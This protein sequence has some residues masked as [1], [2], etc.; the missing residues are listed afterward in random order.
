MNADSIEDICAALVSLRQNPSTKKR[1]PREI[2]DAIVRLTKTHS[3]MELCQKLQLDPCLL[4]RRVKQR[5]AS[6]E[7][8]EISI[9]NIPQ[10]TVII[11]LIAKNG[12]Q[13]KIQGPLS[14]LNCLQQ[15]LGG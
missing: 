14:C 3:Q 2:W 6:M 1:F 8:H 9:Q 7:F 15:I 13:A 11:E 4:K 12:M 5:I 10:E